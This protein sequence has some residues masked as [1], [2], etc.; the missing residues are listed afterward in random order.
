MLRIFQSIAEWT[1]QI[2]SSLI[3]QRDK[4]RLL[5]TEL[6]V[7]HDFNPKTYL[8]NDALRYDLYRRGL[9]AE[10]LLL[11]DTVVIPT[12]DCGIAGV[13]L[14]W[15]GPGLFEDLLEEG[16][17]NFCRLT[18]FVSYARNGGLFLA[19]IEP[20]G[21]QVKERSTFWG[22]VDK[23]VEL[24]I[25]HALPF[26][27]NKLRSR[28]VAK[29]CQHTKE[30]PLEN[31]AKRIMKETHA[32]IKSDDELSALFTQK[33]RKVNLA[34]LPGSKPK[35]MRIFSQEPPKDEIDFLLRLGQINLELAL[36]SE[37]QCSALTTDPLVQRLIVAKIRRNFPAPQ[38][39]ALNEGFRKILQLNRLPD[40]PL[41]VANEAIS[42][43]QVIRLRRS[44]NGEQF[45]KWIAN[46]KPTDDPDQIVE[47]YVETLTR[48]HWS[49]SWPFRTV[50]FLL[51]QLLD[52]IPGVGQ[53]AGLAF[54]AI[55][56]FFLERWLQGY[57]P[58]LF[59][60]DLKETH[61]ERTDH[62]SPSHRFRRT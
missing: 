4:T 40:L 42:L 19:R 24:Q 12:H 45:R 30:A 7:P 59:L 53:L 54:S 13:L 49:Q 2:R 15:L 3:G 50:R 1:S 57:S 23:A 38:R 10:K 25:K 36:A 20:Q 41:V 28:L 17:L 31:F 16:A 44:R 22:T 56:S 39:E 32:D 8:N 18:A 14:A 33:R 62:E 47:L 61:K 52:A 6:Y 9:L 37:L 55:D 27:R 21:Q 35:E 5:E 34:R 51:T 26:I 58:Q 11:Y 46:L 48:K 29:I 43:E 60:D